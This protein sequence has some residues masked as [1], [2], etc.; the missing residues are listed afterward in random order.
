MPVGELRR[1]MSNDE[2][3]EWLAFFTWRSALAN[4]QEVT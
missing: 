3:Q 2:R 4:M 1:R